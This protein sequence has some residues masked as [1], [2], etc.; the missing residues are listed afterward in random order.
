LDMDTPL[1]FI[2]SHSALREGWDNPNVFQICT[3]NETKSEIKKR[4][5]IGRG[6]RLCVNQTGVRN[7]ERNINRLTVIANESY[8]DFARALQKEI[9]EECGVKFEGRIKDARNRQKIALK[10][11]WALDEHFLDLWNRIK[12][13]T[14]YKVQ[15][16]TEKLIEYA[17]EA[18]KNMPTIP[19]PQIQRIK[20]ETTFLRDQNN[21]L[22]TI[23]GDIKSSKERIF[24]AVKYD[25]P[26]FVGYIQSKTELTRD[27]LTKIILNSGRAAD[28]F[29]NPQLFMDSVVRAIKT[30]FEE[31]KVNGI[32]YEK[33][34]G[35][36]YE[37]TLFE[38]AEIESY[39]DNMIAVKKQEKTL[40]NHVLIDAFSKPERDFAEQCETRDDVLFYIKLPS[41]FVVKTPIG[42][43]N[44]DWALIKQ[45]DGEQNKIYFV[46]ETKDPN[47][48]KEGNLREKEK[49][50]IHC[51]SK[52]FEAFNTEGVVYKAVGSLMDL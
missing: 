27:T 7:T 48:L 42:N 22:L 1:R 19:K 6:L 9:E 35:Q 43:Y 26:D 45:E 37:M 15:Y 34:A 29:N 49:M 31:L 50:K 18:V 38:N 23:G 21:R 36:N 33:V 12:H 2:F 14:V 25:I 5:E 44:P 52:H 10:K 32:K 4:Q 11:N 47:A 46:A 16:D 41:W 39:F 3:L 28:V 20:T 8:E 30:K 40:F 51:G 24:E 17:A 13:K